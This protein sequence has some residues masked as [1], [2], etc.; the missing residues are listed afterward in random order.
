MEI[1]ES[2]PFS[3]LVDQG[4]V[5]LYIIQHGKFQFVN[6]RMCEIFGRTR[7]EMLALPRVIDAI[8]PEDQ[9]RVA[10]A[11]RLREIGD[12]RTVHFTAVGVRPDLTRFTYEAHG[13]VSQYLN[14]RAIIGILQD[15][16]A[17]SEE[18]QTLFKHIYD[19]SP[20]MMLSLGQDNV[21]RQVNARFLAHTGLSRERVLGRPLVECFGSKSSVRLKRELDYLWRNRAVHAAYLTL[22]THD[23]QIDVRVDALVSMLDD[24]G[25]PV[26]VLVLED[27]SDRSTAEKQLR[28]STRVFQHSLD[29]IMV[30]DADGCIVGVNPAFTKLTGYAERQA[31]GRLAYLMR[32]KTEQAQQIRDALAR[33]GAWSGELIDRRKNGEFYPAAVSISVV[34]D[35]WGEI[36]N[37]VAVFSDKSA[38]KELDKM[39]FLAQH[40]Q[41]T[42]LPSRTL[43]AEHL[44]K[45]IARAE[46][47]AQRSPA[48]PRA[49]ALMFVDLDRF[50]IVNDTLGHA[51]GDKLL[52]AAAT[53]LRESVRESDIVARIGGD[54]FTVI[55]EGMAAAA[56]AVTPAQKILDALA[57]PIVIDGQEIYVGAS[58]GI[59]CWPDDGKDGDSLQASADKAMYRAKEAGKNQYQFYSSGM[60]QFAKDQL[61]LE[62]GLRHAIERKQFVVY[63][64]PQLDLETDR[65]VGV[66]A[67]VRWQHPELGM[68]SPARFIPSAEETGQIVQLGDWVLREAMAQV[69]QWHAAGYDINLAVNLSPVQFR[70]PQLLDRITAAIAEVEFPPNRLELEITESSMMHDKDKA[71]RIMQ[72]LQA[73]GITLSVDDFGTGHSSLASLKSFRP[74]KLKIDRAFIQ[75]M[76]HDADDVAI[77]EAI[78][79]MAAALKMRT[80][81][82]GI[83]DSSQLEALR[84]MKCDTA[85]G[86]LLSRPVSAD[87][88]EHL[89]ERASRQASAFSDPFG[90]SPQSA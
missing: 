54:E 86:F 82:E 43:F 19:S 28:L 72:A 76:S 42:L 53:R 2:I 40:D 70:H 79:S 29:G 83:E 68:V 67:L 58:I 18:S 37:Y 59:A 88:L 9:A 15:I 5:G 22:L 81:A 23:G 12:V 62:N 78:V 3:W 4:W 31:L 51:A 52:Q 71:V 44:H 10:D 39:T 77:I 89:L 20:V 21:V 38:Y 25:K 11:I 61:A 56:D 33:A 48:D 16:S 8:A 47:Q 85:Q 73:R 27:I 36:Q 87:E 60:N 69:K 63:Y 7:E 65:I 66:E 32:I 1:G 80:V 90:F 24:A 17:R 45:A 46:S 57:Q 35:E 30:V 75:S 64:Q 41:L 74:D 84:R 55:L 26:A 49:L 14:D 13:S 34:R 6:Q 50:K